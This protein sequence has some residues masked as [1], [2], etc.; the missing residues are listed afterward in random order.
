MADESTSN[1]RT[2]PD[3]PTT[4]S[5]DARPSKSQKQTS[6]DSP[7]PA[8]PKKTTIPIT[9]GKF[10]NKYLRKHASLLHRHDPAV[11]LIVT[12]AVG[13]ETRALGQA[14]FFLD[15]YLP[16]LFPDYK[17]VWLPPPSKLDIDLDIIK[18][19]SDP[20]VSASGK[21]EGPTEKV[22]NRDEEEEEEAN[23]QQPDGETK[24]SRDRPDRRF[25]AADAA[26]AGLLFIRFR[27]DV[28]P[29]DFMQKVFDHIL[30][31]P[32]PDQQKL[33]NSVQH[34]YRFLPITHVCPATLEDINLTITP[35]IQTHLS[36]LDP[37]SSVAIVAEVRNNLTVT[38]E[39]VIQ[40]V[41]KMIPESCKI[42]L[43]NPTK[44]LFVTVFKSVCGF[45]ILP[46]YYEWKK[47][48]L[49]SVLQGRSDK[50][51]ESK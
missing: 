36:N 3:T 16:T 51:V 11:G 44:V 12:T 50:D 2:K 5:A 19:L 26:C 30:S 48:N 8:K 31:L 45:A 29:V 7:A 17:T 37:T 34:C 27:V 46:N 33:A 40:A 6:G 21:D 22:D 38:R 24:E 42:D 47:Y 10:K 41:A 13:N 35:I 49:H 1:K 4:T 25:Q 18:S 23:V 15:T 20:G 28:P 39:K 43:K 9:R 32:P 14:R